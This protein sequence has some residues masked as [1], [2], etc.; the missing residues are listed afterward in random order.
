MN[1]DKDGNDR[2]ADHKVKNLGFG[3]CVKFEYLSFG[4]FLA[5][6]GETTNVYTFALNGPLFTTPGTSVD[7]ICKAKAFIDSIINK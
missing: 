6:D 7:S 4:V 5:A 2:R 1:L 3:Y